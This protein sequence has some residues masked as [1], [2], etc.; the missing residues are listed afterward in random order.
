MIDIPKDRFCFMTT[1]QA[2]KAEEDVIAYAV[3]KLQGSHRSN[4]E[5]IAQNVI[6]KLK[7]RES[8]K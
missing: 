5:V 2:I 6:K 3:K 8:L 1:E 4:I 7:Q